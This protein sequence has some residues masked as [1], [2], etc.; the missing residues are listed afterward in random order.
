MTT[1]QKELYSFVLRGDSRGE[2][3]A[4]SRVVMRIRLLWKAVLSMFFQQHELVEPVVCNVLLIHPS[5]KSFLQGRKKPLIAAL[6]ARGLII[7]EYVEAGDRDLIKQRSFLPPCRSVPFLFRWHAAHAEYLLKRYEAQVILTERNGWII[8]S[9]IKMLRHDGAKVVHLAHSVTTSQSSRYRYYDYDYY[10]LFGRSSYEYLSAL[11]RAFGE[12]VVHYCG[13]YFFLD[14]ESFPDDRNGILTHSIHCLFL[15]PGPAYES[16][17]SYVECCSW[18]MDWL[19]ENKAARL[20]IKLHPRGAGSW[21][22]DRLSD[23][24]RISILPEGTSLDDCAARF[25]LVLSNYTNAIVDVARYA[26]P[27]VLLGAGKDYFAVERFGISRAR[28]I[29]Q[30]KDSVEA[31]LADPPLHATRALEFFAFH[32]ENRKFPLT[33]IVDSLVCIANKKSLPG[34]QLKSARN[35]LDHV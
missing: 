1:D 17:A 12:C 28:S 15:A 3:G 24:E 16:S 22:R 7:E 18:I 11:P 9:F 10:F 19:A 27:F 35:D 8:P 4:F 31:I 33:S 20:W 13:P 34:V 23:N 21:W 32:V 6:K 29:E 25:D 30:L 26:T 14:K 2:K 5:K